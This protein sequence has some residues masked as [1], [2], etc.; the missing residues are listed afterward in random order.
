[1]KLVDINS[2]QPS[3]YNPRE[4]DR[5]RLDLV[6]LSLKK[7]GF[8]LPIYS[9]KNGEILSGHQRHLVALEMGFKWVPVEFTKELSLTER[10]SINIL[11]NRGTNDLKKDTTVED[12]KKFLS[13]INISELADAIPDKTEDDR[14]RCFDAVEMSVVELVDKNESNFNNYAM[15]TARSLSIKGINMPI[16]CTKDLK[17]ING[18]GR[19]MLASRN[20]KESIRVVFIEDHEAEFCNAMLNYLSM[21]FNLH[22]KYRDMLRF[23]A[24][25]R[26][27]NTR[28]YLGMAFTFSIHK[29]AMKEFDISVP[30]NK[31][32][33]IEFYGR[34]VI[35]FG[36]GLLTESKLLQKNG[37]NANPFEPFVLNEKNAV[38]R[39]T[40]YGVGLSFIEKINSYEWD[41]VF[42]SAI[43]NSIPFIEDRKKVLIIISALCGRT[44]RV[45]SN[46][47]SVNSSRYM[48]VNGEEVKNKQS[49]DCLKFKLEY[50]EGITIGDIRE[51]PKVQKFHTLKEWNELWSERFER[52]KVGEQKGNVL[53]IAS[54]PKKITLQELEDACNFEFNMVYP[55][56]ERL[57]LHKEA[58]EALKE[59]TIKNGLLI[60]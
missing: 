37:V 3:A 24:F 27:S 42:M 19:L 7:L 59:K 22:E 53:V 41:S 12:M 10:K 31:K 60:K 14:Y 34:N 47:V 48:D 21:D 23:N 56:G 28:P 25:R 30:A 52:V 9:D 58:F 17:V 39:E 33:W 54:N 26:P 43:L 6:K 8:I 57:N 35:D 40:T 46:S 51:T 50:E 18:I 36:A 15:N 13:T 16:I 29:K 20:K 49:E 32:K 45:F 44:T 38:C 55:D 4:N 1:M 5:E 2:V 11:F